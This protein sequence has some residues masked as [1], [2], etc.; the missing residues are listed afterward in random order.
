M[1]VSIGAKVPVIQSTGSGDAVKCD[2]I[3]NDGD[4]EEENEE[5]KLRFPKV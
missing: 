1:S 4:T 3:V 5:V 2:G